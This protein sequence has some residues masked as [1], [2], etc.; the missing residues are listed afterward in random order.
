MRKIYSL[1][2]CFALLLACIPVQ[3]SAAEDE[4]ELQK[5]NVLDY[6]FPNGLSANYAFLDS[7]NN[8]TA[9]YNLPFQYPIIFVD[10]IF[11]SSNEFTSVGVR[12]SFGAV[13][14]LDYVFLDNGLHRCTGELSRYFAS[15]NIGFTVLSAAGSGVTIHRFDL[16]TYTNQGVGDLGEMNITPNDDTSVSPNYWYRQ[17]APGSPITQN[18]YYFSEAENYLECSALFSSVNWR[19]F[20]YIDFFFSLDV[21]NIQSISAYILTSDGVRKFIP[22]DISYL[23]SGV[24]DKN[25]FIESGSTYAV[26][27]YSKYDISMRLYIPRETVLDGSLYICVSSKYHSAGS[28][29]SIQ[30]VNGYYYLNVP[31]PELVKMD[32]MIAAIR[33]SLSSSDEDNAAAEDFAENMIS[34]KE[35]MASNQQTL[36]NVSKPSADD[37]GM[38]VAPD[39]VLD[40]DGMTAL[41]SIINPITDSKIVLGILTLSATLALVSYVFFGKKR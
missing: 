21:A 9:V 7:S 3:A 40:V 39:A 19:N 11:E 13:E 30:S 28:R 12:G 25:E 33:E 17:S 37:L 4:Y 6:G 22:F 27:S 16:Y 26:P 34:Q 14:Y 36:N 24:I 10:I 23:D 38:M 29:A 20:D 15:G 41:V 35:Q 1:I 8:Y 32:Q 2:I 5:I 18:F 31:D